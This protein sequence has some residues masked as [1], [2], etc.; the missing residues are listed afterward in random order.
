MCTA[1]AEEATK[2][3][4]SSYKSLTQSSYNFSSLFKTDHKGLMH[5][6]NQ[7]LHIRRAMGLKLSI[8]FTVL[9]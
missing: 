7:C 2:N 3:M 4:N 5:A 1:V 6:E 8:N 9:L